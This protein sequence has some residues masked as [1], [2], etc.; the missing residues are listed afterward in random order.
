MTQT[1]VTCVI[2]VCIDNPSILR[3]G[4]VDVLLRSELLSVDD[5]RLKLEQIDCNLLI[6]LLGFSR[7]KPINTGSSSDVDLLGSVLFHPPRLIY[8]PPSV[9]WTELSEP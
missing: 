9:I 3:I 1:I 5:P 7:A 2:T 8:K 4:T 6:I